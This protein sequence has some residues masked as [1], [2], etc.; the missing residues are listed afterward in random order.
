[1]ISKGDSNRGQKSTK[2]RKNQ[3]GV[4]QNQAH[5]ELRTP[6]APIA[7]NP[8]AEPIGRTCRRSSR[9]SSRRSC[10]RT[11]IDAFLGYQHAAGS[12]GGRHVKHGRMASSFD[13]YAQLI[14]SLRIGRS[15]EHERPHKP[16]LLLAILSLADA[17][18]LSENRIS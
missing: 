4:A 12:W 7:A 17:G 5:A 8:G 14:V 6:V 11:S 18:R 15:G 3:E 13:H 2:N 10:G 1:V 16:A 9:N